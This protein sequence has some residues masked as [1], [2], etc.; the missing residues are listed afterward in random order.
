[1]VGWADHYFFY[2]YI[3]FF[4]FSIFGGYFLKI[5]ILDFIGCFF[6]FIGNVGFC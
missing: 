3:N 5:L 6:I 1:M 2:Y 4:E